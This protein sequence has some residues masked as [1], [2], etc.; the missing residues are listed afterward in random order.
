MVPDEHGPPAPEF[1]RRMTASSC[2]RDP[3]PALTPVLQPTR[4]PAFIKRSHA[5][6]PDPN[7]KIG[8]TQT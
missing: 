5:G 6:M 7:V 2:R 8:L 4:H 3:V 1:A